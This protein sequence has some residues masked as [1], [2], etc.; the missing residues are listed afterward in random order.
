[1]EDEDKKVDPWEAK[2]DEP[3]AFF[4]KDTF[5]KTI[6]ESAAEKASR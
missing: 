1:M 6:A 2:D 5:E 4:L 3:S